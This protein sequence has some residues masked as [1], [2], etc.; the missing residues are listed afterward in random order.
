MWSFGSLIDDLSTLNPPFHQPKTHINPAI[1]T[2]LRKSQYLGSFAVVLESNSDAFPEDNALSLAS[3]LLQRATSPLGIP[4]QSF[5]DAFSGE[6]FPAIAK[7]LVGRTSEQ[8]LPPSRPSHVS[9][10]AIDPTVQLELSMQRTKRRSYASRGLFVDRKAAFWDTL[11]FEG[12]F[13]MSSSC[14]LLVYLP[15]T[16]L[17]PSTSRSVSGNA[18][19]I[20][21]YV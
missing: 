5:Q 20:S 7:A 15:E 16:G 19:H 9:T 4:T 3:H 2:L 8:K 14:T 11:D 10:I 6:L 1:H 21:P 13:E 12:V 18:T 17:E